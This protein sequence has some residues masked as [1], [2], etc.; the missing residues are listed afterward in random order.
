MMR[1]GIRRLL[2][3]VWAAGVELPPAPPGTP[4]GM[5]HAAIARC[6]GGLTEALWLAEQAAP[7]PT[8]REGS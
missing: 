8:D 4:D 5:A 3:A 1:D 6:V 7:R 2:D